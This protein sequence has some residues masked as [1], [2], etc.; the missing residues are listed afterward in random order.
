MRKLIQYTQF[1]SLSRK[2]KLI[3]LVVLIFLLIIVWSFKVD[4]AEIDY[5]CK[6]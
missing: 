3:L 2:Q 4:A 1:A 5:I 6:V